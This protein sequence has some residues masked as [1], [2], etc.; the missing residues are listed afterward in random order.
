M[1]LVDVSLPVREGMPVYPGDPAPN[2]SLAMSIA[3]GD[4]ANVTRLDFGLHT[5][6]H[7]DAPRHF[8]DDGAGVEALPLDALIGPAHVA[9]ATGLD[10]DLDLAGLDAL[11]VPP[12]TERL[13]LHTRNSDLWALEDFQAGFASVAPDAARALV[14]RGV[15]LIGVDYLSV[16]GPETHRTLLGAGVVVVEGLDLRAAPPGAVRVMCLPMRIVGADGAPARVVL[17]L[18]G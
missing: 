2:V 10:G 18:D 1:T 3:G 12:G 17:E 7:I 9:D 6:T 4:P 15:R 5:G 14:E 8:F 13:L 16:G 11:A